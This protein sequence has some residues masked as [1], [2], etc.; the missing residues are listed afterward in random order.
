M[1]DVVTREELKKGLADGSIVLLDVREPNEYAAGHIPGAIPFP[2]SRFDP[3]KLPR[4]EGKR[5]V[6]S[7]RSG[8]RTLQA[9]EMAR[10]GGR[11]DANTHYAGSMHDWLAA[12]ET[13]EL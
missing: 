2:L 5:V 10:L 13:V 3:A 12:G 6:F 11:K 1:V 9:I 7:C 8:Q 4:E